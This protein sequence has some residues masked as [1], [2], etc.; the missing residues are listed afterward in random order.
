MANTA[1]SNTFSFVTS[2]I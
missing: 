1:M 2:I